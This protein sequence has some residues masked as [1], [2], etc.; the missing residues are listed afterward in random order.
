MFKLCLPQV[1]NQFAYIFVHFIIF[2]NLKS[3]ILNMSAEI[4]QW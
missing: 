1:I 2:R 3:A 4:A